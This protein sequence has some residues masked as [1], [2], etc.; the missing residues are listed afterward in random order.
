MTK[1]RILE[2][3]N[4]WKH[5]RKKHGKD[6]SASFSIP[7]IFSASSTDA[8]KITK[9]LAR[10]VY[11]AKILKK[12]NPGHE[13]Y[14]L[15]SAGYTA[16]H[17]RNFPAIQE[18][19]NLVRSAGGYYGS[20]RGIVLVDVSEWRGKKKKKFFDVYLAYLADQYMN[21]LMPFIYADFCEPESEMQTLEAVVSSYFSGKRILVGAEDL[22]TYAV[23]LLEDREIRI[24]ESARLYL[25]VFLRESTKS[26]LFHGMETVRNICEGV[27]CKCDPGRTS[28]SLDEARLKAIITDLGY[29]DIYHERT[30]KI[31]GFR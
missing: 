22:C 24:D 12:T 3:E 25:E 8:E 30:N 4:Q 28:P 5:E 14:L 31:M 17:T 13:D 11:S 15:F 21:G 1:D 26:V 2:I 29:Y 19:Y 20:Y 27:A 9:K 7:V 18:L 16:H 23:S 10:F 6:A